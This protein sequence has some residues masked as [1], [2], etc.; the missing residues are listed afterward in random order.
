MMLLFKKKKK[1]LFIYSWEAEKQA[2]REAGS[3][4]GALCGTWSQDPGIMPWA[5]DRCSTA[6]PPR[7]PKHYFLSHEI[8]KKV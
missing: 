2:E 6:E 5:E 3:M 4:Q 8:L 1:I 7:C